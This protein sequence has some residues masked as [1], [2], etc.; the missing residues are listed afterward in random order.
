MTISTGWRVSGD[1][2][3]YSKSWL[4]LAFW[5]KEIATLNVSRIPNT[6]LSLRLRRG[7]YSDSKRKSRSGV[8][9]VSA[10]LMKPET[11]SP[12]SNWLTSAML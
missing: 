5:P 4:N 7:A 1:K 8:C 6:A 10:S 12:L 11:T 3:V 2:H 9:R